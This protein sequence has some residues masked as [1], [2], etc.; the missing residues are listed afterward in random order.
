MRYLILTSPTTDRNISQASIFYLEAFLHQN[1][2]EVDI[3]DL[4]GAVDFYDPPSELFENQGR[5][6]QSESIFDESWI[7]EYIPKYIPKYK[8]DYDH[9]YASALFSM[10]I[11]LQGRYVKRCKEVDP[12]IKATIGGPA[13]RNLDSNQLKAIS[14]V[15]DGVFTGSLSVQPDYDLDSYKLK[16]FITIATG[17]GCDWGKCRFCN[18][19]KEKY[20]LRN[21][22]EIVEEILSISRLS[23]SEIMLSSDSISINRLNELALKLI[24]AGNEQMYNLMM[25]A[26]KGV[27][28]V[29]SRKL[30]RSGCSDVFVGGEILDDVMLSLINKGLTVRTIKDAIRYLSDSGIDVQ[31]GLILF[32]PCVSEG[33]LDTQLHNTEE[34]LSYINKIELESLSILYGS[35][36]HKNSDFYGINLYPEKN[37]IFPAWCYGLSPDVPWGFRNDDDYFMWEKHI[38]LL[39]QMTNG[40]VDEEYWWHIDYIKENWK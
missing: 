14:S 16:D 27:N 3:V 10:D 29:F 9:I 21:L 38:D 1:G 25:R 34:I 18:S 2:V 6:W 24:G 39:R 8:D 19:G 32:L 36:F 23:D 20:S 28:E 13:V 40:Y 30:R 33:Q 37:P 22:D 12:G 26:G 31:L 17:T 7:D 35:D 4:S 15:F 5:L 11:I